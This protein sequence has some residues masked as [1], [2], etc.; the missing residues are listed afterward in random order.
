MYVCMDVWMC[1]Y[2]CAD[3]HMDVWIWIWMYGYGCMDMM[4]VYGVDMDVDI[5]TAASGCTDTDVWIWMYGYGCID[6]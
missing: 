4:H 2:G 3:M 1:G 6:I 5:Y